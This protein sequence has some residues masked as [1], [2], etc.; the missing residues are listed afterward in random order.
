LLVS[1]VLPVRNQSDHIEHVVTAYLS[2]LEG[3][4][5]ELILVVNGCNDDTLAACYR[6]RGAAVAGAVIVIESSPGWGTAVRT[7][8]KAA[9]GDLL[10]Y[11]NSART[12]AQDL[13]LG[14]SL[15]LAECTRPLLVKATRRYRKSLVRR[16]ASLLYNLEARNLFDL[17]TWDVNGTPKVFRRDLYEQMPLVERGDLIDLEIMVLCKRLDATIVGFDTDRTERAG[18]RSTTTP[19][20]AVRLY[21]QCLQMARRLKRPVGVVGGTGAS[22]RTRTWGGS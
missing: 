1:V 14:V 2:S 18:G 11:T 22:N 20:S 19:L 9:R 15:A 12:A 21:W 17:V 13:R 16:A 5:H 8:L 3:I 6:A 10:C 7:G 4:D